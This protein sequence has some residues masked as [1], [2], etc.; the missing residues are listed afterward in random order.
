GIGNVGVGTLNWQVSKKQSWLTLSLTSGSLEAGQSTSITATV[1]REGQQPGNYTDTI[2]ITSNSGTANIPVTMSV[3]EPSPILS[4]A[5][6]TFDFGTTET[7][8]LLTITNKGG[9]AL[10]WQAANQQSWLTLSSKSGSL[11]AGASQTVTLTVTRASALAV[12]IPPGTYKDVISITS[13][14]GNGNINVAMTIPEPNP[15]LSFSPSS[16]DFG[17]TTIQFDFTIANNGGGTLNWQAAK[18]Q[19]WISISPVKGALTAGKSQTVAVSVNRSGL[20]PNTY[21]DIV[22][23]TSNDRNGSINVS[24]IVPLATPVLAFSPTTLDFGIAHTQEIITI[25]N[26]G[27]GTLTWQ[28][29]RQQPWLTLSPAVGSLEPDRTVN[30]TVTAS[31]LRL[32]PGPYKDTISIITNAGN[33]SIPVTMTVPE[34]LPLLSLSTTTLDFGENE[35]QQTFII[36]NMGGGILTWQG[37]KQQPWLSLSTTSGSLASGG[38]ITI[39]A[40]ADRTTIKPGTQT[41]KISIASDGG[42]GDIS[43]SLLM[44][45]LSYAPVALEFGP[46]DTQK[47]FTI[48]NIGAGILSWKVA[49]KE[50]W[51]S[52]NSAGGTLGAGSTTTIAVTVSR[53]GLKFGDFVDV[54]DLTSNGG[55][56]QIKVAM[57]IPGLAFSPVS[58]D[59]GS[60]ETSKTLKISNAGGGTLNWKIEK[61]QAWVTLTPSRGAVLAGASVDVAVTVSRTGLLPGTFSDILVISSDGGG[62]SVPVN[63]S[64][65][66]FL[67]SPLTLD[68]GSIDTQKSVTINNN[69]GGPVTWQS[70]KKETWLTITPDKGTVDGGKTATVN[71]IISRTGLKPDSYNDTI[72]M[73]SSVG[74]RRITVSAGVAGLSFT[75]TAINFGSIDTQVNLAITNIGGGSLSFALSRT[76]TWLNLS[77]SS[78]FVQAGQTL[79]VT[80]SAN[81]NNVL[82]GT[83]IDTISITSNGGNATIPVTMLVPGLGLSPTSFDFGSLD[84]QKTL[85]ITN[86]GAGLLVWR[87]TNAETWL[88]F[89]P[90][91]G[92]VGA[93]QSTNVTVNVSRTDLLPGDYSDTIEIT[94]NGGNGSVP[95][96]MGIPKLDFS[97]NLLNFG[98][99]LT[100]RV[101]TITNSGGG[102]LAWQASKKATATWLT[103][104]PS[105]GSVAAGQTANVAV[106]VDKTGLPPGT[107]TETITLTSDGGGSG[108]IIAQM[109]KPGLAFT[110]ASLSFSETETAKTL[111]IT[112]SGGGT[113]IWTAAKTQTWLSL[114]L[115]NGS[116]DAGKSAVINVS[117]VRGTLK[118]GTYPDIIT[119]QTNGGNAPVPV[120]MIISNPALNVFPASLAFGT[121]LTQARL[122]MTNV[123]GGTLN[124]SLR[125]NFPDWMSATPLSG[126]LTSGN[127][128]TALVTV[129]RANMNP[130]PNGHDITVISNGGTQNVTVTMFVPNPSLALNPTSLNFGANPKTIELEFRIVN[131]GG[132]TLNWNAVSNRSNWLYISRVKNDPKSVVEINGGSTGPYGT[133]TIYVTVQRDMPAGDYTGAINVVSN[134]SPVDK[135]SVSVSMVIPF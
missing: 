7:Q 101:F 73:T 100:Q 54:I 113:L 22:T 127:S 64:V 3:S 131:T 108:N 60:S 25:A 42:N 37:T 5:P 49:K 9:G 90:V 38:S 33:G 96:K 116:L 1:S 12:V 23:L 36:T 118:P 65:A 102:I 70:S 121:T 30:I 59:F 134:G 53:D 27:G 4:F 106:T 17:A 67:V 62:G 84:T 18:G 83:Q 51:L 43:V 130:G 93:G 86:T 14:G 80:L 19:A 88:S 89:A 57:P 115:L 29:S 63:I 68:F 85:I 40:K 92:T 77:Q 111:T 61:R 135:G 50:T 126:S 105:T 117:I 16:L 58:F 114:D 8:K 123:G 10:N 34:P 72:I 46:A 28:V 98:T 75:P 15:L 6:D 124:W 78:G 107:Y 109:A 2:A 13:D 104:T 119:L 31:R 91:S 95:V 87:A 26:H 132:G 112:N 56:G 125:Q 74:E 71:V 110:P 47:T 94:Y 41:D 76:Q 11:N 103:I 99:L 32:N 66:G 52:L 48:T 55:T 122:T 45:G 69:G 21:K 82:P 35:V 97:P 128:A 20:N 133:T 79:V 44:P 81:R 120:S 24:M 39:T 129:N